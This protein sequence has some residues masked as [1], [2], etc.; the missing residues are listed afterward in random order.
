[1]TQYTH[2]V[3]HNI[4]RFQQPEAFLP[5]NNPTLRNPDFSGASFRVLIARLS[6]FR[7]TD[8]STPHLFLYQEVRRALPDAYIDLAFFPPHPERELYAAHEVPYLLG[9]QSMRAAAAFDLVLIS[10]AYT[11]ELINLPYL[12][13]HSGIPLF[14]GQRGPA[15]PPLILGGSNAMATQALIAAEDGRPIDCLVDALFFGEGEGLVGE[16][17]RHLAHA[18]PQPDRAH[19]QATLVTFAADHEGVWVPG[20]TQPVEKAIV[21]QPTSQVLLTDAPLLNSPAADTA[22]LQIDYGCPAFCSFCFEGYDRK[23]YRKLAP[24]D[25]LAAARRIKQMQGCEDLNLYSFNL[26]THSDIL[27]LL[28]QL[29]PLFDRLSLK[30]QRVDLLQHTPTLLDAEL[31]VD[32]RS[33]TLG[34]EGISERMRAWLHKSLPSA[35]ILALLKRLLARKV[36]E[37]KLFYILTGH[38]TAQDLAEFRDFLQALKGM[39]G[40]KKGTRIIFSFGLLIRMPFTPLRYDRLLLDPEAW[41]QLIGPAKSACE[42][43]GFEFRLAFDWPAYC[44]NQVLAM[45]G[46]WLIEP[47]IALAKKGYCFEGTLPEDYWQALQA[48]MERHGYWNETFLGPKAPGYDFAMAFVEPRIPADFLYSQF[49][50][51]QSGTDEGYCLGGVQAERGSC[52]GCGACVDADQRRAITDHHIHQPDPSAYRVQLHQIAAEKR[53]LKPVYVRM[54]LPPWLGGTAPAFRDAAVFRALLARHPEWTDA[55]LAVR[56]SLFTVRPNDRAFPTMS[57]ET[58]F[59][60]KAWDEEPIRRAANAVAAPPGDEIA[61]LGPTH[62]FV[63][64]TYR[65]LHLDL[66]LPAT[67]LVNPRRHLETY[68]RGTYL[69]YSLHREGARYTFQVPKKGR[70]KKVLYGGFF[71]SDDEG[72][73]ATLTVGP[74][75]D[76]LALMEQF[77]GRALHYHAQAT[78]TRIEYD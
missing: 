32:K 7:D 74:K 26:N 78:V 11:L 29:A 42:T 8:R 16:L 4:H 2:F 71:E 38:E 57:G 12:L 66:A 64:G 20:A 6:P 59:A 50:R 40:R 34:I 14:A 5:F 19:K 13:L 53:Q 70:K 47:L 44:T 60:L 23:P 49:Q 25:L 55:L 58:V 54:W 72:C 31:A 17:V 33:F 24:D 15:W 35:D 77:G 62:E 21:Q 68:F 10:N 41:K 36:R 27:S 73:R 67:H 76:L 9:T 22:T 28:L 63:P 1:M 37:I 56:E 45:G 46:Y 51:C 18:G 52:L 39:Q 69:P 43:N 48:W 30:S 3:K 61:I 65:R 75:F